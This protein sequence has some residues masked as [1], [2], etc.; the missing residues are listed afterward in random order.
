MCKYVYADIVQQ[1]SDNIQIVYRGSNEFNFIIFSVVGDG[2][3]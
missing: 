2:V 1:R 3:I